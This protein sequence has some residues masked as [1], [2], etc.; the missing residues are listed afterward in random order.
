[1][2]KT[3]L[4]VTTYNALD[5]REW[6][7]LG[8]YISKTLES[9]YKVIH[10]GPLKIKNSKYY[11]LLEYIYKYVLNK[12]FYFSREPS[13]IKDYSSQIAQAIEKYNPDIIFSPGSIPISLLETTKPIVIY[14]DACFSALVNYYPS[15][16]KLA[17]RTLKNGHNMET[18]ALNRCNLI[19]YSTE[20]AANSAILNYNVNPEKVKV[21]PFGANIS[22]KP[23]LEKIT[24]IINCKQ[25]EICNLLFIGVDWK[26]KGGNVAYQVTNA[27]NN[28]GIKTIL[29]VIGCE[30]PNKLKKS[31]QIKNYGF[32]NKHKPE[33]SKILNDL[34]YNSH[35]LIVPTIAE[36]YGLV[37]IEANAYGLP[38]ITFDTGGTNT[39]IKNNIN[40]ILIEPDSDI[41]KFVDFIRFYFSNKKEYKKL[42]LSSHQVF[43]NDLSWNLISEKLFNM[44]EEYC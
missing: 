39:I 44:I 33:D 37:F 38:S 41:T 8:Y 31:E 36:A 22:E 2:R 42:A 10:L 16:S 17:K 40:G 20:W 6:S 28:I 12:V 24:S 18:Q 34:F 30:I 3:I 25:F 19:I 21:L 7:G 26:R 4:Y 5:I 14:T 11:K 29:H 13:V 27:L 23:T 9:N 35:F 15:Y 1:M 32:L 43:E